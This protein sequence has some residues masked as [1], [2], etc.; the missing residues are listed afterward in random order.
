MAPV[1]DAVDQSLLDGMPWPAVLLDRHGTIKLANQP[2]WKRMVQGKGTPASCGPGANYLAVCR[3]A[4]AELPEV[5]ALADAIERVLT[6]DQDSYVF[7]YPVECGGREE[8]FSA[9]CTP[10][11]LGPDG[12]LM[13]HQDVTER[14]RA[15]GALADQASH[16]GLTGL[17][18]RA[19]FLTRLRQALERGEACAVLFMDL[20]D[21]KLINDTLGHG[22][23]DALLRG[24]ADRLRKAARPDD[25]IA[26]L[27][28]DE[29]T[30]LMRDIPDEATALLAAE[31]VHDAFTAPF[32]LAGQRRHVRVSVGCRVSE[33]TSLSPE[34]AAES[35]LRD[36]DVALYQAKGGGKHRVELFSETTRASLV[37]RL[38]IEQE[39]RHAVE[40]GTLEVR[41]QPQVE[42]RSGT[43]VGIE[44]LARWSHPQLGVVTPT[45]FVSVAEERGLIVE[46]GTLVL[47]RV[48]RQLAEWRRT[49]HPE[50]S[51][52]V[53]VSAHQLADPGFE[54]KVLRAVEASGVDPAALCLEVTESALLGNGEEPTRRL[55]A[56]REKGLYVAVDDFGTG[57]SSLAQ[58]KRLPVDVLK[59]DRAFVDGLGTDQEDTA[60]VASI[61]SLAGAMGLHVIAEGV[62]TPLQAAELTALGCPV[63][64]GFL[65]APA[66][67]A[68]GLPGL[69]GR[70]NRIRTPDSWYPT[71]GK[72]PPGMLDAMLDAI[73]VGR[74]DL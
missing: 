65:F 22:V 73:G 66:V 36:A 59:I 57:W 26:R 72:R 34:E 45:E 1:R 70:G 19:T 41:F 5:G 10:V 49:I 67:P 7:D 62:E 64:Q 31:R 9:H 17:A 42:L 13:V 68:G 74:E 23:G 35:V 50:L 21:F 71:T 40:D 29:F 46:L 61:L 8:W 32:D 20:D 24:V 63:G 6:G 27:G 14:M 44:A 15:I 18:N 2:W 69:L 3:R 33:P 28:G 11:G 39:L 4:A 60:I 52:T 16:D 48:C 38:D 55:H 58:L 47:D 53:N 54:Q 25:V 12:A 43:L 56:L 37:R 30:V 51:A